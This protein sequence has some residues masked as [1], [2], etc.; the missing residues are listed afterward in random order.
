V[1]TPS[2][3]RLNIRRNSHNICGSPRLPNDRDFMST[4]PKAELLISSSCRPVRTPAA[5]HPAVRGHAK[6]L[7][8][9]RVRVQVI[10]GRRTVHFKPANF[11]RF[12][13]HGITV[14]DRGSGSSAG[15]TAREQ[16]ANYSPVGL[17]NTAIAEQMVLSAAWLQAS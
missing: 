17:Q 3:N 5:P 7:A 16:S 9:F 14:R 12:A 1:A 10:S 2:E 13:R 4:R 15:L 6:K 8:R 11:A